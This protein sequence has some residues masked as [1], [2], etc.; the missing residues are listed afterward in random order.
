MGR[1]FCAPKRVPVPLD[2]TRGLIAYLGVLS[3]Y[4]GTKNCLPN[5]R[6]RPPSSNTVQLIL[7]RPAENFLSMRTSILDLPSLSILNR[8]PFGA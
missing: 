2:L 4:F 6:Q 3:N 7:D 8:A 1:G 5:Q